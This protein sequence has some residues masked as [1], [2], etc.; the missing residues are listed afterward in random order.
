MAMVLQQ[1]LESRPSVKESPKSSD[2]VRFGILPT[3]MINPARLIHPVETHPNVVIKAIASRDVRNAQKAAK[4]Y[5]I[6]KTYGPYEE[7]LVDPEI[8]AVYIS[9]PTGCMRAHS[10][11]LGRTLI[12]ATSDGAASIFDA[13]MRTNYVACRFLAQSV[14]CPSRG[15]SRNRGC[16]E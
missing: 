12:V 5:K 9:L 13:A 3:A 8:D 1:W 11:C 6:E 16:S 15:L 4:T 7:L 14:L 10:V 2:P